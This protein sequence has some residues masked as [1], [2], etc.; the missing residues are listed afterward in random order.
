V[1]FEEVWDKS[2][3]SLSDESI[4]LYEKNGVDIVTIMKKYGLKANNNLLQICLGIFICGISNQNKS[5][6]F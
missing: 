5:S 3:S 2:R 1:Y 4:M 6:Q